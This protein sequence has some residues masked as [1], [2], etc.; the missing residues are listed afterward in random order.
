MNAA[1]IS[2]IGT[3]A[4]DLQGQQKLKEACDGVEGLFL[5]ILLKEGMQGMLENAEGHSGSALGYALEQ[6]ADE[7]ARDS[8]T[9]I[10]DNIYAQLSA[11][12]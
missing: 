5:R 6:T 8:D 2:T 3:N 9:G 10:A 4:A 11:N 12:L 1:A 7:I